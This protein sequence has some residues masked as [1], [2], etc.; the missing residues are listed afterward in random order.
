VTGAGS[1]IDAVSLTVCSNQRK[2]W[3]WSGW[4]LAVPAL[5][6]LAFRV[7]EEPLG[8]FGDTLKRAVVL[9]V[10]R[11]I[12]SDQSVMRTVIGG[13]AAGSH[14]RGSDA[15]RSISSHKPS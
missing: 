14:T 1:S 11:L 10:R 9:A 3:S 2:T 7:R 5:S 6:L 8:Q 12:R 13:L 4:S 15:N